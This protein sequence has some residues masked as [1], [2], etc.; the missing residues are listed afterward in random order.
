[1]KQINA[2]DGKARGGVGGDRRLGDLRAL[3]TFM[4]GA[5]LL[6]RTGTATSSIQREP[7]MQSP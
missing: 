5:H 1:M 4:L 7:Q 6:N 2:G 3:V